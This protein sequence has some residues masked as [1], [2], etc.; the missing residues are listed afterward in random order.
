MPKIV[1]VETHCLSLPYRNAVSFRGVKNETAG[2]YAVLRLRLDDG[3]EGIAESNTRPDQNGEDAHSVAY[4][5]DTFF[6]ACFWP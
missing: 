4:R 6:K 5:I 1:E 3:T 2:Q